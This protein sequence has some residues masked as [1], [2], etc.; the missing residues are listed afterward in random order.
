MNYPLKNSYNRE[1]TLQ[2][3]MRFIKFFYRHSVLTNLI[4][5]DFK[6]PEQTRFDTIHCFRCGLKISV[7][8]SGEFN[9]YILTKDLEYDYN[10]LKRIKPM[11]YVIL[12]YSPENIA[13]D[14]E[15]ETLFIERVLNKTNKINEELYDDLE[16][17]EDQTS[18]ESE[19]LINYINNQQRFRE[20]IR[21]RDKEKK[22]NE[23]N[24]KTH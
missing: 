13:I 22:N 6:K 5:I 7:K 20:Y 23:Q 10:V 19:E 4:K 18:F 14:T 21:N 11:S 17:I 12:Q 1:L 9:D 2:E 8:W 3:I 15:Y 16:M 24:K